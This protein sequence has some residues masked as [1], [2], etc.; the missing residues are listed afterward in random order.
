MGKLKEDKTRLIMKSDFNIWGSLLEKIR[1][2]EKHS[3]TGDFEVLCS[4]LKFSQF[5]A[6]LCLVKIIKGTFY[7]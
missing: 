6:V 2:F 4:F 1:K 7:A 3:Y 5:F